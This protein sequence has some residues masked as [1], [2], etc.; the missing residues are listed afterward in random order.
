M[1]FVV[2]VAEW[3]IQQEML[4]KNNI[5]WTY[6]LNLVNKS[7]WEKGRNFQKSKYILSQISERA[8]NTC[9]KVLKIKMSF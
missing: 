4:E 1:F 7:A 5:I 9:L 8:S 3:Q 6:D 2:V